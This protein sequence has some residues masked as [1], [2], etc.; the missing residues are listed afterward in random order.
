MPAI[1][2]IL[3]C[4]LDAGASDIHL[5]VG[6]PPKMRVHGALI[7][8][9]FPVLTGDDTLDMS[10]RVMQT[11]VQRDNFEERGELDLSFTIPG[12]GRYRVNVF[13]QRG[14]VAMALR[15]VTTEIPHHETLGIPD[16][17]VNLYQRKRGLILV[18][19]PTGSGKST[20]LASL[21]DKINDHRDAHIITLEDP[22]EYLHKHKMSIVNQREVG[23]D[24]HSYANALRAA[25]R[26]DPDV[27]L[28]GEMRDLET[29]SIAVRAAETGHLVLSTLHTIGA[30]STVD[31]I[32]DVYPPHQQQQIR[33][34]LA[35]VL[36]AV[37]SQQLIPTADG[38]GRVAAF[39]VMHATYPARNLIRE[40]KSYQ[41]PNVMQTGRSLGMI[42]M[43]DSILQLYIDG[44][45]DRDMAV[46]FAQDP[47]KMHQ[48][49]Y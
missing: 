28:V 23:M 29:I 18:T 20:T 40:N 35:N 13:K 48:K 34:Q 5:T 15:V 10:L 11:Q 17:V 39:E 26:E 36:E 43:D 1:E 38:L 3:E 46:Q 45:I 27:I 31:R 6:V 41:L 22:I 16:S 49:I 2:T 37:I 21:I 47:E 19:G 42:T 44:V 4:A 33:I 7:D 12:F 9:P 32:I 14:S 30:A 25:L 8:M 24:T